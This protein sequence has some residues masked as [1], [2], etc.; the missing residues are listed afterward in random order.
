MIRYLFARL[1]LPLVCALAEIADA[2]TIHLL[3]VP[4]NFRFVGALGAALDRLHGFG[5]TSCSRTSPPDA[6]S[7]CK[8]AAPARSVPVVICA[9]A[10]LSLDATLNRCPRELEATWPEE[11]AE[12]FHDVTAA[13]LTFLPDRRRAFGKPQCAHQHGVDP[14]RRRPRCCKPRSS[15]R[16]WPIRCAYWPPSSATPG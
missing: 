5:A 9:E 3:P 1:C 13:E 14:R 2:Y 11:L 8:R 12:E 4:T 7:V 6:S 16:R 15:A 10:R